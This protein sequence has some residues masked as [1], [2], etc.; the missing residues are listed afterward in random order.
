MFTGRIWYFQIMVWSQFKLWSFYVTD[1]I[2]FLKFHLKKSGYI[3]EI[4][5]EEMAIMKMG[6]IILDNDPDTGEKV[7]S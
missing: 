5:F 4:P 6:T 7:V 3:L 1:R 2:L